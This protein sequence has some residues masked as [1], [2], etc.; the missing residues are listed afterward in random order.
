MSD[1]HN[2]DKITVALRDR[3]K[4]MLVAQLYYP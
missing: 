3:G 4:G 2:S 1:I